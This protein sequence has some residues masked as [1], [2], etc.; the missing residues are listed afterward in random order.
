MT[1]PAIKNIYSLLRQSTFSA[2]EGSKILAKKMLKI[3]DEAKK[4]IDKKINVSIL[5]EQFCLLN[6]AL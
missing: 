6:L 4:K 1:R 5:K 2:F 3:Y